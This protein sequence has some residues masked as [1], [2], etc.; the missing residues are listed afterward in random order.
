MR[1]GDQPMNRAR[2]AVLSTAAALSLPVFA[3]EGAAAAQQAKLIT[4]AQATLGVPTDGKMT[5]ETRAALKQFQRSKGLKPTGEL[6]QRTVTALGLDGPKPKPAAGA[7][8]PE[9]KPSTP[10][11]PSQPSGERTAEPT[12]KQDQPT[13]EK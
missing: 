9:A 10:V 13:G 1:K 2:L 11:G 3:D 5:V 4:Q 7:S 8:A 12:L 6:D